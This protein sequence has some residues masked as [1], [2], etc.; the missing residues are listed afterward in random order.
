MI[1]RLDIERLENILR[2]FFRAGEQRRG[3]AG[4]LER[5]FTP[6]SKPAREGD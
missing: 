1:R 5:L 3:I 6:K 4:W 2:T